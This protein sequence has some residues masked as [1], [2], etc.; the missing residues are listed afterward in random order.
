MTLTVPNSGEA[1]L[2]GK[3]LANNVSLRLFSSDST[4]GEAD[5]PS[6]YTEVTAAGYAPITLSGGSW[7]VSTSSGVTTAMYAQ[8]LFT[9]TAA[10]MAYGYYITDGTTLVWAERFSDGP[11]QIGASGGVIRVTP[12]ITGE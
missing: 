2:L 5:T 7:T 11:Y 6:T 12:T 8:Q 10:A 3:A 4:P 1:W 9:L